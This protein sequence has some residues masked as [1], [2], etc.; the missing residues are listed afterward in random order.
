MFSKSFYLGYK[1]KI[2]I[3]LAGK[4]KYPKITNRE[5][6]ARIFN[7]NSRTIRRGT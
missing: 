3:F 7:K 2:R 5:E 6:L 1:I 4:N